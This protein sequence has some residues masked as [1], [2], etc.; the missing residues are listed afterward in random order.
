MA[1]QPYLFFDGRTDEALEYYRKTLDAEIGMVMRFKDSP[2]GPPPGYDIPGDKVMHSEMRVNGTLVMASDGMKC[3]GK[4]S[5]SGFSLTFEARD[6][7]EAKR[8]FEALAQGGQVQMPY[9][10]TFFA[11]GFGVVADK[12]GVSWMVMTGARP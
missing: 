10:E 4:P 6:E 12:F 9:G 8:R 7:A 3:G 5:F 1:I 2:D 11:K